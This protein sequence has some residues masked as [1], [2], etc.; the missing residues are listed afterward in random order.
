MDS[1]E[2]S[3]EK[4]LQIIIRKPEISAKQISQQIHISSRMVEKY[5]AQLKREGKIERI[6][7]AK[8][9]FWKVNV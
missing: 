1:N 6:G 3:S 2:K 8:G 5:I 9:G 4:I 7:P